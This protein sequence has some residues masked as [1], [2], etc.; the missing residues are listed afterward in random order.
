[1]RVPGDLLDEMIAEAIAWV[2]VV[3]AKEKASYNR[4]KSAPA[5]PMNVNVGVVNE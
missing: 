3:F 2:I 5:L 4:A 1:L